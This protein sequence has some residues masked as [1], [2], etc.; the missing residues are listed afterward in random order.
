MLLAL[1]NLALL[2]Q[3][4]LSVLGR[5]VLLYDVVGAAALAALVAA[6]VVS[7]VRNTRTLSELE[8][9]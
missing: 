6:L 2:A 1:G 9:V 3:P 4:R 5:Q 7:T 8:R